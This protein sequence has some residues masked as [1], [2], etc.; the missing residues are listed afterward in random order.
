MV[1][2][3]SLLSAFVSGVAVTLS[4]NAATKASNRSRYFSSFPE[5][6]AV[7]IVVDSRAANLFVLITSAILIINITHSKRPNYF[8]VASTIA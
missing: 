3:Y 6:T 4:S 2:W 1:F 8:L 5:A 7:A